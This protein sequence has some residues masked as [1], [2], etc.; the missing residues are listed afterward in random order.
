MFYLSYSMCIT[1]AV[2]GSIVGSMR[3]RINF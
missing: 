2:H 3:M 1:L